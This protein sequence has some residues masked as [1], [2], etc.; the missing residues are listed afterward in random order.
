VLRNACFAGGRH[1]SDGS[2]ESVRA[3]GP[4]SSS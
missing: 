4:H 3:R 1:G 2:P